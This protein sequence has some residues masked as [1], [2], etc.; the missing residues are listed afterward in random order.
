MLRPLVVVWFLAGLYLGRDI[1]IFCHYA[2]PLALVVWVAA[3]IALS[4]SLLIG[5]FGASHVVAPALI[6]FAIAGV[7]LWRIYRSSQQE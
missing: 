5:R 1:A 7:F 4:K 2:L 3:F 6:S